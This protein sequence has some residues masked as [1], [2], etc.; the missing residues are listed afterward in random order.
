MANWLQPEDVKSSPAGS[1]T[2]PIPSRL[3]P[4]IVD[5]S[6]KQLLIVNTHK[7][8][9]QPHGEEVIVSAIE[10]WYEE[11]K[12]VLLLA[13][14]GCGGKNSNNNKPGHDWS[15]LTTIPE[16]LK[17]DWVKTADDY[18]VYP[19]QSDHHVIHANG[20][21][22]YSSRLA[23]RALVA[24]L[25]SEENWFKSKTQM[26]PRVT[27]IGATHVQWTECRFP[28]DAAI[29]AHPPQYPMLQGM[30]VPAASSSPPTTVPSAPIPADVRGVPGTQTPDAWIRALLALNI[31]SI[32]QELSQLYDSLKDASQTEEGRP[33]SQNPISRRVAEAQA[34]LEDLRGQL[35]IE[36]GNLE[37]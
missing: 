26:L 6:P 31:E 3:A 2:Q 20:T 14:A 22:V 12:I 15:S 11:R 21:I 37:R 13:P 32:N 1:L 5:P 17:D 29:A 30:P 33:V 16:S 23:D 4:G 9:K 7:L 35:V 8:Y 27:P 36:G 24:R 34:V 28:S 19:F 10:F 25:L 18:V